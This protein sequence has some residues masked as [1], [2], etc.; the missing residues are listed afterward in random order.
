MRRHTALFAAV[1]VYS[2]LA[3]LVALGLFTH[4]QAFQS[5]RVGADS[6]MLSDSAW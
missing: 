5:H 1:V 2:I 6:P 4:L 3:G